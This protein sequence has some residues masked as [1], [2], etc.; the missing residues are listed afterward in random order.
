M[1]PDTQPPHIQRMVAER[2][3]LLSRI[4]ALAL[5]IDG[6]PVFD[7]LPEAEQNDM[8]DQLHHMRRYSAVLMRRV[9]RAMEG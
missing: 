2:D 9:A 1:P 6:N 4:A 7:T 3:E 5:F 8:A